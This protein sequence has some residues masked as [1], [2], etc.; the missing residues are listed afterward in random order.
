VTPERSE[1]GQTVD[2]AAN[3]ELA[4]VVARRLQL[5]RAKL[6]AIRANGLSFYRPHAKQDSF[7]RA[8]A[9]VKK[10]MVRA[11]NRF[12]KSHMGSAEDCAWLRGE[13]P[14][15]AKDDPA[16]YAGIP[17]HPV[18]GLVITTDWD[19]VDEIWTS[20]RGDSPGKIWRMLPSDAIVSKKRNHSG[21]IE[22]I[23]VK[24]ALYDGNSLLKFDTVKSFLA[25]PMGSESS[26]WDFVHVDEPCPEQM[27]K[28][29][30]RGLVDR[31]GSYWFTLTPLRE[32][33]INDHFFPADTGGKPR[34]DVWAETGT[35]YDNPHLSAEGIANFEMSLTDEEK[36][37]RLRGIPL[38]LAGLI[39]KNFSWAKHV[40][41]EVPRGWED[42]ATPPREWPIYVHIDPHPQTPHAVLFC[43]VDP[44]GT[45]YYFRDIFRHCSIEDLA[46]DI[47][48]A[49]TERG[50]RIHS[51]YADPL[52]FIEH[53]ITETSMA[54]EFHACGIFV[55]KATKALAQGILKVNQ[56]LKKPDAIRFT[57]ECR[58]TLWEIQRYA[59]DEKENKP[60]DKDDHMMENLY[61]QEIVEPKWVDMTPRAN[62]V[63]E[64]AITS[65]RFDL[66]ETFSLSI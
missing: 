62:P 31:G 22:T 10:R 15:Y 65:P 66:D 58:R 60:V 40:L 25:N 34:D 46:R 41:H 56:E 30:L 51:V 50:Y 13:R 8:A 17:K 19:K 23:E 57:P 35:I 18:K 11:G 52:A 49:T 44:F 53:P 33:W 24:S 63:G 27:F 32:A 48:A 43:T 7:H 6:A 38:H 16:R 1:G 3:P 64:M 45:R 5:Q 61:R 39:Y 37:C 21:A 36:E 20:E 47:H 28:A 12:G 29:Q 4:L 14:W 42:F 2:L 55:E 26:D 59:W 54:T 9:Y